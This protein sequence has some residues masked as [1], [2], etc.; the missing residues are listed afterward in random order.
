[1]RLGNCCHLTLHAVTTQCIGLS[2]AIGVQNTRNHSTFAV[3]REC[4][5]VCTQVMADVTVGCMS[6]TSRHHVVHFPRDAMLARVLAMA[7][8][9]SVCL[10]V[11]HKS[12]L[13]RSGWMNRAGFWHGSFLITIVRCV[14]RKFGCLQK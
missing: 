11:C 9:L 8:C 2:A 10:S 12:V 6:D 5:V 3:C 4:C 7:P 14:K 13:Y 1:L